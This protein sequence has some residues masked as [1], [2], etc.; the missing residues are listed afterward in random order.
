MPRRLHAGLAWPHSPRRWPSTWSCWEARVFQLSEWSLAVTC[1]QGVGVGQDYAQLRTS[2]GAGLFS[3][4]QAAG[5]GQAQPRERSGGE[6]APPLMGTTHPLLLGGIE[7]PVP[8]HLHLPLHHL[9]PVQMD[10]AK[11]NGKRFVTT[12]ETSFLAPRTTPGL[13]GLR[14]QGSAAAT[15]LSVS[16]RFSGT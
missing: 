14:T 4:S 10:R 1:V 12:Q 6:P 15:H 8:H 9:Q 7:K 13:R 11:E 5:G 2:L 3:A 16:S